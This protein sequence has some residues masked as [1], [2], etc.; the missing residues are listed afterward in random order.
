MG[1]AAH[2]LKAQQAE[3]KLMLIL[4]DAEP[5]DIDSKDPQILIQDTNKAL[6]ELKHKGI[7]SYCITLDSNADDYVEAIFD[8]HYTIINH[9]E[10]LPC[11]I[12]KEHHL[13][14]ITYQ[15]EMMEHSD[16]EVIASQSQIEFSLPKSPLMIR[17]FLEIYQAIGPEAYETDLEQNPKLDKALKAAYT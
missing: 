6:E 13:D 14:L 2:Y 9:M 3:K 10:K 15:F 8:N 17:E 1:H 12:A 7:Y 16:F 4:T 5:V 11:R